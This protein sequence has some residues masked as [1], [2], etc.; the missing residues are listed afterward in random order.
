[1]CVLALDGIDP[2]CWPWA[3]MG[4]D[5]LGIPLCWWGASDTDEVGFELETVV[6]A[7]LL[8]VVITELETSVLV[9]GICVTAEPGMVDPAQW[10]CAGIGTE[11]VVIAT[12]VVWWWACA[13]M[14]IDVTTSWDEEV[15][16]TLVLLS[17]DTDEATL[18]SVSVFDFSVGVDVTTLVYSCLIDEIMLDT[19]LFSWCA[20]ESVVSILLALVFDSADFV[21]E[22]TVTCPVVNGFVIAK[23]GWEECAG[24]GRDSFVGWTGWPRECWCISSFPWECAGGGCWDCWCTDVDIDDTGLL[25][26]AWSVTECEIFSFCVVAM[27]TGDVNEFW[28][29][30]VD[31]LDDVAWEDSLT[32]VLIP[33]LLA[34]VRFSTR[35]SILIC[36]GSDAAGRPWCLITSGGKCCW[37]A[38]LW[39]G[40]LGPRD[41][42]C[43]WGGPCWYR[44]CKGGIPL[45][46]GCWN[47]AAILGSNIIPLK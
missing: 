28:L 39:R 9:G 10:T 45:N 40:P 18:L 20:V 44:G 47:A 24:G 46:I 27:V 23:L 22:E 35:G 26:P 6:T 15:I 1:M 8:V 4:K 33:L 37:C 30:G 36:I 14:G 34:G 17:C 12:V 38:L 2:G 32:L 25:I 41:R 42:G 31:D 43:R 21:M 3:D 11:P 7:W 13:G 5:K 16:D 19:I 29:L